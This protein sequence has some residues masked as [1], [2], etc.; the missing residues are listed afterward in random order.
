VT[1]DPQK[2]LDTPI[3]ALD[4]L[5]IFSDVQHFL[6][7]SERNMEWMNRVEL[8]RVE[9]EMKDVKTEEPEDW[10]SLLTHMRDSV[11]FRFDVTLPMRVRYAALTSLI[12]TIEWS[13]TILA[14]KTTF[15]LPKTPKGK[16][17]AVH[18]IS[19]FAN[20]CGLSLRQQLAELE[21]LTWVRNSISH[22]SGVL[23]GYKFEQSI[24]AH[25]SQYESDFVISNWHFIGDTVQIK[26]GAIESR[27]ISWREVIRDL[28]KLS[29][30]NR[31][32]SFTD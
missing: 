25:V 19:V 29:A 2:L 14:R 27:I 7:F 23:K 12:A 31:L 22:N 1:F 9:R 5:S 15:N 16:N 18:L 21:F 10:H 28:F 8:Q 17:E 30:E 11:L 26:R 20:L 3:Y 24:R 32:I 4:Q 6:E 13:V